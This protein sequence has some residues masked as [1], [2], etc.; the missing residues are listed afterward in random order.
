MR[1]IISTVGVQIVLPVA[2][3]LLLVQLGVAPAWALVGSAAISVV[4]LAVEYARTRELS[5]LGLL[6][7]VQFVLGIAVAGLTGNPRLVLLKDYL[8]TAVVALGAA[9]SLALR[10]PFIARVRRDLTP[11][12]AAFDRR[13]ER[14]EEFRRAHRRITLLWTAGLL[15]QSGIAAVI[16]YTTPLT[17]AVVA[18]NVLTPAALIGLIAL[19]EIG[20]RK[21]PSE[22]VR[23]DCSGTRGDA[24][25]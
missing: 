21:V 18:T 19:T 14:Q 5:T 16:I 2:A 10:R 13:W 7:L 11:D 25:S 15:L 22:D 1:A 8:I 23:D 17:V 6:V 9:G 12:R 20:I 3:Y 4:A 24:R